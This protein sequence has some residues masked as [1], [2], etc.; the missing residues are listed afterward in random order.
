MES[1]MANM[2]GL[3]NLRVGLIVA[4][5][6][7]LLGFFMMM[8]FRMSSAGMSPIYTG[9]SLEDSAKIAEELDKS[10]IPYELAAGGSQISVPADKVL[11]LR[12]SMAEQGI[13]SGG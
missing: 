4:V 11:R 10:G 3:G 1:V 6:V 9:L 12:L 13:P 7:V 5:G 2:K 8:A